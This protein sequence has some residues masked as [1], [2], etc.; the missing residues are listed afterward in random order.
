MK[1]QA[2]FQETN[3]QTVLK[4]AMVTSEQVCAMGVHGG[5]HTLI[6]VESVLFLHCMQHSVYSSRLGHAGKSRSMGSG[7][8]FLH[9]PEGSPVQ[10]GDLVVR[11]PDDHHTVLNGVWAMCLRSSSLSQSSSR[12]VGGGLL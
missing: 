12:E 10:M 1:P 6:K 7:A 9:R 2:H 4:L 11:L 8:K 3:R 5:T